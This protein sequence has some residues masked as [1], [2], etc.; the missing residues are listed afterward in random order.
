MWR[1]K[2]E[3]KVYLAAV[4]I[5]PDFVVQLLERSTDKSKAA[6][7]IPTEVK[8]M[9]SLSVSGVPTLLPRFLDFFGGVVSQQVFLFQ[10]LY[11]SQVKELKEEIEEK[12]KKIEELKQELSNLQEDRYSLFA[13]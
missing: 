10:T 3:L 8:R 13:C 7:S 11:K 12:I 4:G 1:S 2:T 5:C 9:F 6:S